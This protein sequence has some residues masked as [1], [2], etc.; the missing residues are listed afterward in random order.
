MVNMDSGMVRGRVRTAASEKQ[1]AMKQNV[2]ENY[3]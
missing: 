1:E 3:V 2:A